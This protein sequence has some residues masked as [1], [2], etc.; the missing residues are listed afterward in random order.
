MLRRIL[1]S[2]TS[3]GDRRR[4]WFSSK[5]QDLY[6]WY[7]ETENIVAFQL[8]YDKHHSEHAI[9][10][11]AERG[12]AH[13]KVDDGEGSLRAGTPF[14]VADGHFDRDRVLNQFCKLATNIPEDISEFVRNRVVNYSC[15]QD[16]ANPTAYSDERAR[17]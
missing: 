2:R 5:L 7:D 12:F 11:R 16:A 10:W 1:T 3:D 14:L 13:L 4:I 17:T 6:V 15:T 9:Y 8:C